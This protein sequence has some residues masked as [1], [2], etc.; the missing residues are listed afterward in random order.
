MTT[1]QL[2]A[3]I[4]IGLFSGVLSGIFGVGGGILVIPALVFILGL[5]QHQAQGTTLAMMIP[6]IGLL[7]A[8]NYWKEGYINWKFALV[9]AVTLF[10]GAYFG[11]KIAVLMPDKILRKMFGLLMFAAAIKIFFAK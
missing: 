4:V 9:L 3:L 5:N 1:T 8:W 7:A 6:P 11:S 2:I 10:I